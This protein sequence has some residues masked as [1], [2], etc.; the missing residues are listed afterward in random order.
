[1]GRST[2]PDATVAGRAATDEALRQGENAKLLIVF[3]SAAYDLEALLA[4]INERSG[5]APLIGCSTAGEIASGGTSDDSVVVAAL[6][7]DG[8]TVAT[9]SAGN[10]A[11]DLRAA[12]AAVAATAESVAAPHRVLMLLS[13]GFA[14]DQQE[15]VR[16]AY[17]VV[18]ATI[19]LV[20][21]AASDGVR[22]E[23][24]FQ[25]HDRRVLSDSVVGATIGSDAPIGIGVR[26][27]WQL[28]GDPVVVTRST[29]SAIHTLD[30][31]PALDVYLERLQAP[32][33][34]RGDQ[35]EFTRFALTRPL[36]LARRTGEAHA[37][38]VGRADFEGGSLELIGGFPTGALAWFMT[39]DSGSVLDAAERACEE[40]VA[41]LEGGEPLG[42]L[43]FDCIARREILGEEGTT[44][45][46]E[47]I[48]GGLHGAPLAGF[49][50]LGEIART[51][52]QS[53][54]H[55]QTLVLLVFS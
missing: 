55:N 8:F 7:G 29:R 45:E 13:D 34:A 27:G 32:P 3:A 43:A 28:V 12:G 31:D 41:G 4:A 17:E 11:L 53:G 18:G 19:R 36:G 25:F 46:I 9:A 30:D 51:R 54:F 48:A 14:V 24:T 26:H 23:R 52:G 40:A 10:S 16:G 21:G 33:Q 42:A 20:G 37:R 15:L 50:T 39:G 2:E 44:E 1:V 5:G 35:E 49:Y 38:A 47:R 6:G 22:L